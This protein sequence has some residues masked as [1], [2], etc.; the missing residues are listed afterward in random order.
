MVPWHAALS[1]AQNGFSFQIIPGK[2]RHFFPGNEKV[3]GPLGELGEIDDVIGSAL[4]C[5]HRWKPRFP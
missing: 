5:R 4:G 2:S 3:T 1:T